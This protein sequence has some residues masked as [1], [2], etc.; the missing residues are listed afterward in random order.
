MATQANAFAGYQAGQGWGD[1]QPRRE[2]RLAG[3]RQELPPLPNE[4]IYFFRKPID[5]SRVVR[6]PD[7]AEGRRCWRWIATATTCTLLL[8]ALLWPG[9]YGILAGYQI[10]ALKVQQ[11]RLLAERAALD[12]QEARLLSPEKLEELARAQ[13]FIDPAPNQ[14]VY[15]PPSP[16]GALALNAKAR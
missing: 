10:E 1:P 15:L 7:R 16:D 13:E 8:V 4:S 12:L 14:V 11:D 2:T 5:N 6:H 9:A 3:G